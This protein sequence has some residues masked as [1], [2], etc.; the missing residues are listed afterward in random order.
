MELSIWHSR[1]TIDKIKVSKLHLV[2]ESNEYVNMYY[3][4]QHSH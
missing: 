2:N 4:I 1:Y 3:T